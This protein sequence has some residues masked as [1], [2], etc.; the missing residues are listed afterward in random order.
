VVALLEVLQEVEGVRA[1]H[2]LDEKS[3]IKRTH[4]L[5]GV[6]TPLTLLDRAV[7]GA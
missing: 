5:D 4:H 2:H 6:R 7:L 3:R 1:L